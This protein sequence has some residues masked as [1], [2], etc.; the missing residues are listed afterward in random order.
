MNKSRVEKLF[1]PSREILLE[2]FKLAGDSY[3]AGNPQS[4]HKK[5]KQLSK[6]TDSELLSKWVLGVQGGDL[7]NGFLRPNPPAL[8]VKG[9]GNGHL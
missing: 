7:L 9:G 8:T 4:G 5:Q 2:T 3:I 1:G 6:K